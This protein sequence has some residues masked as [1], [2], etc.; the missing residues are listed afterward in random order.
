[1]SRWLA[2]VKFYD[3]VRSARSKPISDFYRRPEV[4]CYSSR[5]SSV[6]NFR[7]I[8][9]RTGKHGLYI[10]RDESAEPA[11]V[12]RKCVR[13]RGSIA[14]QNRVQACARTARLGESSW[15]L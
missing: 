13:S 6:F 4:P 8:M 14:R 10:P 5:F 3:A 1:M 2:R 9:L 11:R 15:Y 7:K 12:P